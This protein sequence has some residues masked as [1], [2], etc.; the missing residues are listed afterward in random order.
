MGRKVE[1]PTDRR[2]RCEDEG[3]KI[4]FILV[5]Q[6]EPGLGHDLTIHNVLDLWGEVGKGPD[7][8]DL[9]I[10]QAI[11]VRHYENR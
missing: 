7:F 6:P 11:S 9:W 4:R 1:V 2:V 10:L 8:P 3:D 5:K